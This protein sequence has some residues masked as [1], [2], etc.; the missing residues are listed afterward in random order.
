VLK[1]G[2]DLLDSPLRPET[3]E[4]WLSVQ[5]NVALRAFASF[6]M[7]VIQ[8]VSLSYLILRIIRKKNRSRRWW[9]HPI[10]SER[11]I[12]GQFYTLYPRLREDD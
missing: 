3:H 4:R 6:K 10:N 1:Y 12:H 5:T 2:D 11:H 7:D 9:V 8:V